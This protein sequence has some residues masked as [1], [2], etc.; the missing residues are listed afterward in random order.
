MAPGREALDPEPIALP[1]SHWDTAVDKVEDGSSKILSRSIAGMVAADIV[2]DF[3]FLTEGCELGFNSLR[4]AR[5]AAMFAINQKTHLTY[6]PI[7]KTDKTHRQDTHF[8][9]ITSAMA[10]GKDDFINGYWQ[11]HPHCTY[12]P[13]ERGHQ[14]STNL[15]SHH[16]RQERLAT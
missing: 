13:K 6:A 4:A 11:V 14:V 5:F 8:K 9:Q 15:P 2:D 7:S 3:A 12:A 1:S 10:I 16:L